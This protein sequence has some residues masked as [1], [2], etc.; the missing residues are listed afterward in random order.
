MM[1]KHTS[2]IQKMAMS[3]LVKQLQPKQYYELNAQFRALDIENDG[4]VT[5]KD[6]MKAV[7]KLG[8]KFGQSDIENQLKEID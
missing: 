7:E 2:K 8:L 4:F 6:L 5:T 1:Y 3:L